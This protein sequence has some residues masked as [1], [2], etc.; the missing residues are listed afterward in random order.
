LAAKAEAKSIIDAL[1][2]KASMDDIM[3]ALYV[4]DKFRHGEREIRKGRGV[5]HEVARKRLQIIPL[6]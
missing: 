4:H 5:T 6:P 3:Y 2:P 1:P